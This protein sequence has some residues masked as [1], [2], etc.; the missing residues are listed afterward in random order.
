MDVETVSKKLEA[1]SNVEDRDWPT[2]DLGNYKDWPVAITTCPRKQPTIDRCYHSLLQAG[3]SPPTLYCDGYENP[4]RDASY[5]SRKEQIGGWPNWLTALRGLVDT[6]PNKEAYV[7]CQDDVIF[8]ENVAEYVATTAVAGILKL[9]TCDKY[10]TGQTKMGWK[11]IPQPHDN[12]L[13]ALCLVIPGEVA[14]DI[15]TDYFIQNYLLN[16][17]PR[18]DPRKAI[19][20]IIGT[21]ACRNHV[22]VMF[23]YPSLTGHIGVT[24]TMHNLEGDNSKRRI[25][26]F[27]GESFNCMSLL[28]PQ[29]KNRTLRTVGDIVESLPK[30]NSTNHLPEPRYTPRDGPKLGLAVEDMRNHMTDEGWQIFAGLELNDYEL[31]GYNLGHNNL[32]DVDEIIDIEEPSVLILQD[33]REWDVKQDDFREPRARFYNVESLESRDDIFTVTILKDA[34]NSIHYHRLS[35]KE[36]GCHAWIVYYHP[37]IV[38]A[39]APFVREK[40]LVRT[41]HSLDPKLV[42]EFDTSRFGCLLSGAVSRAYPLR[43]L[44]IEG[45]S[46]LPD[47]SYKKH[48]GYH[49]KGCQT[50]KYM[51]MLNHY[52]VAI[53]TSSIY[54][55]TLRKIVEATA[56]GCM[57][58]TDLPNDEILPEIDSNLIR[59]SP[60]STVE[61]VS[62]LL[63]KCYAEYNVDRQ[64]ELAKKAI[65]FYNYKEVTRRLAEDIENLRFNYK[66]S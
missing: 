42:P 46:R 52:K 62:H 17:L 11:H 18:L 31:Y 64:M 28:E 37:R 23:H 8:A 29:K 49:R 33:K 22:P 27:V 25:G 14:A 45:H 43:K 41:Y 38:K 7:I 55:Y 40:H 10:S 39:L 63:S 30:P 51:R 2:V 57:V 3:F 21:W 60:N 20:T 9:S 50:A 4:I 65:K 53:C 48:P 24:S 54:G 56:C 13:G 16:P 6:N 26:S 19:D 58:I 36:I 12:M 47:I 44:L 35:A 32:T 34:H 59:I 15:L 61:E 1:K 66:T 5:V